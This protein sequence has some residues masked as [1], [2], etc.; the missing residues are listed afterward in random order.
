MV[1]IIIWH[2]KFLLTKDTGCKVTFQGHKNLMHIAMTVMCFYINIKLEQCF[3]VKNLLSTC[4][5]CRRMFTHVYSYLFVNF[6]F[7]LEC[8]ETTSNINIKKST[9]FLLLCELLPECW[10]WTNLNP[11]N[12]KTKYKW[13]QSTSC[14]HQTFLMKQKQ[15]KSHQALYIP[16]TQDFFLFMC[17]ILKFNL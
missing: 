9:G 12:M 1:T 6:K 3:T 17:F 13:H 15:W 2:S 14:I 8:K 5:S 11:L 10:I 7:I 16:F 4:Q